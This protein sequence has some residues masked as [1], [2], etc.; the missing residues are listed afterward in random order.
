MPPRNKTG[1]EAS[2]SRIPDINVICSDGLGVKILHK[3]MITAMM[4]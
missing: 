3:G 4:S 2:N 1:A